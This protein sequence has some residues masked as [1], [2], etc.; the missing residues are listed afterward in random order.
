MRTSFGASVTPRILLIGV[1]VIGVAHLTAPRA[2]AQGLVA[3]YSFDEGSGTSARDASGSGNNGTTSNATWT[4]AGRLGG[5]LVFNGSSALVTV[6]GTTSL[7]LSAAM[8]LEAWVKPTAVNSQ[9]RDVIYKGSDDYYLEATSTS[10]AR[11]A[12]GG[13]FAPDNVYGSSA[14]PVNAWTHLAATYDGATLKLYVNGTLASSTSQIA[15]IA[16]SG[17]P[18]QIGGDSGAGQYF[19][20]AIDEVRIYSTAISDAQIRADMNTPIGAGGQTPTPTPAPPSPADLTLTK[21]HVG[22]FTQGQTGAYTL[23]VRNSGAGATSGTVTL[24][25]YLPAGL[26]AA[27]IN[28][29]GWTCTVS[30]LTCTRADALAPGA[31]YPSV[32]VTVTV[33][34]SAPS[35]V[36]NTAT[37][38]GGGESNTGNGSASDVTAIASVVS[39]S[40]SPAPQPGQGLVA[41]Y[42]FDEGA[43]NVAQ[44]GSSSHNDGKIRNASWTPAGRLGGALAFNG[45]NAL[46]N[47]PSATSLRPTSAVTLEAWVKPT[48]V[49]A[50]W[51]DVIYKGNDDY[52]LEATSTSSARPAAGGTFAPGNVYGASAIPVDT[53]THLAATYDGATLRMY[54]NGVLAS[55]APRTGGMNTSNGPLQIGGDSGGG[56]YFAGTIDEV[57]VYD[58]ALTAGEIQSDMTTPI[59]SAPEVAPLPNISGDTMPPSVAISS[60][61]AGAQVSATVTV[62]A[63]ASDNVGVSSVTFLVDG[64]SIGSDTT[65]PYSI[66]WNTAA[67]A[68]GLHSL[69]ARAGDAAGNVGT[70]AAVAVSIGA[71]N[72]PPSITMLSPMDGAVM[73]APATITVSASVTDGDGTVARVD[74]YCGSTL[75]G[76]RTAA[77][78]SVDWTAGAAGA[79][80]FVVTAIDNKG[81]S[82]TSAPVTV[83]VDGSSSGTATFTPSSDDSIVSR[84]VLEIFTD[85]ANVNTEAPMANADLGKPSVVN[86]EYAA[87]ISATLAS[88][89]NGTY[90]ATVTAEA[91]GGNARSAPSPAFA[92]TTSAVTSLGGPGM[93][94]ASAMPAAASSASW[95]S[96]PAAPQSA[97]EGTLWVTSASAQMVAAFDAAT[98]DV[99]ATIP[100][101]A[102]PVAI[103]API[104]SSRV[105]VADEDSDTVSVIDKATMTRVGAISLPAPFGR[106][107]HRLAQTADGSRVFVS[108]SGS[109]VVDVIDTASSQLV[110]RFAAGQP[111]SAILAAIPDA[112]GQLVYALSRG[113]DVSQNALAAIEAATGR[114][115]WVMPIGE[116]VGDLTLEPDARTA[117][118]SV[119][120]KNAI[121][122]ID[123]ERR[124][125]TGTVDL[126]A[127]NAPAALRTSS[128]GRVVVMLEASHERIGIIDQA[129]DIRVVPLVDV[130]MARRDRS[131]ARLLSY[132]TSADE[133]GVAGIDPASGALVR[134]FRLPGG[135]SASDVAFD[136]K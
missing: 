49:N 19:A 89:P 113:G 114:W 129:A 15:R 71:L 95:R 130:S 78:F 98:G 74:F 111:G 21:T 117:L 31:S 37:A 69:Q 115:V 33:A 7:R 24:R 128:D 93:V 64:T 77:P 105:F 92:I 133:S 27:G 52:Y 67:F 107:P 79:Y 72:G 136:P 60:P 87:N 66:N 131:D 41:A 42:S 61:I 84:Y 101:G 32:T 57:R 55:S 120:A 109:N 2:S 63:S 116:Q 108:E 13:T 121:L 17:G 29:S 10:S 127:G 134:R 26:T 25:D 112:T 102:K 23:T 3:A 5:A 82:S 99:L 75:I 65:A 86:G 132:I 118:I 90:V 46:V 119:P 59:G 85:G 36:T 123:L 1:T 48:A 56:Q 4:T 16:V 100:V 106:K 45:T 83:T 28:G 22:S 104:G 8:T 103:A 44:D 54:V 126:G 110:M 91:A 70:S 62:T 35:S 30:S 81:A 39:P 43:G 47:I 9:W 40:P 97:A 94:T 18:L 50:K 51:R 14:I 6:P 34:T 125:S 11:P 58:I 122:F 20:G 68:A 38:S 76:S 124:V 80:S 135:G 53:W 88:L 73:Q 96:A 12:A